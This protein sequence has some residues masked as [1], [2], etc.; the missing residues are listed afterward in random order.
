M[1]LYE[2]RSEME[3]AGVNII[4]EFSNASTFTFSANSDD[5]IV[6]YLGTTRANAAPG[7]PLNSSN[8]PYAIKPCATI[9]DTLQAIS[10][11]RL[12]RWVAPVEHK[13]DYLTAA[14][15]NVSI[16]NMFG[17]KYNVQVRP[18]TN[19]GVDT[20]FYAG[21]PVG[22]STHDGLNYNK[23]DD[24]GTYLA[25]RSPFISMMH[26]RYRKNTDQ[27]IDMDL[28]SYSEVEF[29]LAEAAMRGGFS[30]SGTAEE[31]YKNGGIHEQMGNQR[32]SQWF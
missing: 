21:L 7:G 12:H 6:K 32:R 27:Y 25:E 1:R 17:D 22:L 23:G 31:H 15:A 24:L 26:E 5:A 3:A 28:I 13:W 14:L 11:P 18:T 19:T 16:T 4:A 30:I 8:P 20:S 10:D 2:K 9:V 29:L